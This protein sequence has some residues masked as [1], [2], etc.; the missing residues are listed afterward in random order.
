MKI[1]IPKEIYPEEKRVATTPEVAEKLIK[2]GF[3][4]AVESGAGH[5]ANY[6]DEVYR[7]VGVEVVADAG[8]LWSTA[9]IIFKVRAPMLEEVELMPEGATLVSFIWPA[10]NPE[11]MKKLAAKKAT[12]LAMDCVPRISRAQKLD[13]LS[14]MA[15]IAG[16]RAVIEAAHHFGRFFTGQITAAGKVPPAKVFV[17]GAG[18]AG[19]A[20]IGAATGL[21]AMVRA[22][23]T[24][25]E[26]KD[27]V[28]SMGGEFVEVSYQEEGSGVGGY[29]KVMSEGYQKA[30]RETFARQAIDVDII[31]TTALIPGK[32]APKL[33]TAGMV[34]SMKPGSVIV[35]LAAEQGG[36]CELT[37]PGKVVVRRGVTIIG[38]TDLP[39]RLAKQASS[40]YATN[41]LHLTEEM[42]PNKDGILSVNMDDEMIRG[43][44]AIQ[45]GEITWPPP[46]LKVPQA[47]V[48]G[49][50][51]AAAPHMAAA[52]GPM[53]R[54][55]GKKAMPAALRTALA[56]GAGAL[57]FFWIGA[58]APAAFMAHFTV[59]V[60]ACF[61]GY[62]VIWNVT[63]ALH[64]PLMSVTNAISSIIA[65]GALIQVSSPGFFITVLAGLAI[66][67]TAV[68]MFGGF[69]V[70]Q[71][72]LSMFRK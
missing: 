27:Q 71:R 20:A 56:L 7:G 69:W 46:A 31:I 10:Q 45:A 58:Y 28:K 65:I 24:R 11:L 34:E 19:L 59:F 48:P 55:H 3:T 53:A 18:V 38:Y 50:A 41:L 15:N 36:N 70:T 44:T 66:A 62:M 21:G 68:N 60:L 23:D 14:S 67:L 16:Y 72:M 39:S 35:D 22:N 12:V 30:Q 61:I 63:P 43:T 54:A 64:T 9:D 49:M 52:A 4:V 40:L 5:H 25:P 29:A 1:G 57:V 33:I 26:V 2:L 37:E 8:A 6:S 32:P 42:C 17:I 13:A 51:T 47:P